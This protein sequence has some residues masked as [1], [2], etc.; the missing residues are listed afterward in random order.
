MT[1]KKVI[2]LVLFLQMICGINSLS[3]GL[4]DT[5]RLNT[6]K[7]KKEY[8][9]PL[10]LKVSPTAFL[11]G[12]IFPYTSE[13]RLSVEITSARTQSEQ[14]SVSLLDKNIILSAAANVTQSNFKANGWRL[15]YAHKFYLIR[16]KKFAP[17][18]LYVGALVS[19]ARAQVSLDLSA[20]YRNEYLIFSKFDV[21][22]I[23]GI[24]V[25]KYHRVTLDAFAGLGYKKNKAFYH[26]STNTTAPYD[27]KDLG[28]LYNTSFNGV[29]AIQV[30]YSL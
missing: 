16:K 2:Q 27:T 15:Q 5:L 9:Q 11:W 28:D 3:A 7:P 21:N 22:G 14:L 18:G 17:Y 10:V 13:Y 20:Y 23:V 12:G 30:G 8:Y 29:F 24:Q 26:Y 19:Y 1:C 25:G 6:V 4:T